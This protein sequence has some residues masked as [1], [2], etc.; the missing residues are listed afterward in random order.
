VDDVSGLRRC[1]GSARFGI[2]PHKAPVQEFPRQPS[3]RDG[4]GRMCK[5]HWKEYTGGL[6]RGVN[7]R[8]RG[9]PVAEEAPAAEAVAGS[10]QGEAVVVE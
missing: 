9:Q 5:A 8:K 3:Q 7:A 2:E 6:A 10:G 1:L 4:L